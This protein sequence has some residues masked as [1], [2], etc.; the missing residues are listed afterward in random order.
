M[1]PYALTSSLATVATSGLYSDLTG[2]PTI[3]TVG[4]GTI[5][6]NQGGT[7]KGTFTVN[8]SGNTTINLDAGGGGGTV[9][10]TFDGTSQNAQSGVAI[11]GE[12]G[13][14]VKSQVPVVGSAYSN[15]YFRLQ[16]DGHALGMYCNLTAHSSN[17]DAGVDVNRA[18]M[19]KPVTLYY[20]DYNNDI[21]NGIDITHSGINLYFN[22]S[23]SSFNIA[24]DNG[25]V[26]LTTSNNNLAVN[27]SEVAL[28]SD[29]PDISTKQDTLVSGTNIKTINNT[30]LL[31]SGNISVL[32]NTATGTNA[33]TILGTAS[34]YPYSTN[35]GVNSSV[36]QYATAIGYNARSGHYSTAIGYNAQVTS[37]NSAIQIGYGTNNT[38][39][40]LNIGFYNGTNTHYNWQLLD[41]TTGLIPDARIS[42]N[43]ARTSDVA[44]TNLSNLSTTGQAIIDGKAD[45]DLS[46]LSATGK[47]VIDGGITYG[48][49]VLFNSHTPSASSSVTV[50]SLPNDGN[51]YLALFEGSCDTGSTSGNYMQVVISTDLQTAGVNICHARTRSASTVSAAGA[52]WIPI[53]T[54][55][56]VKLGYS[57]SSAFKGSVDVRI[58]EY[59]RL[60]TNT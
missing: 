10:Q 21:Y 24:D 4:N 25:S 16:N 8:Q 51:S 3:P 45:T 20:D 17:C 48:D 32:Q 34:I 7:Q 44:N 47:K 50:T 30:S 23:G 33:L 49:I 18:N 27:G 40:T 52:A 5:P 28:K 26:D 36:V 15:C 38:A 37:N 43:I 35:I 58:K 59:R 53:G 11:E 2:L 60:G 39:N 46:N 56:T 22:G 31:G 1:T 13:K 19:E 6:I 41:G 57:T 29:I 55:R 54:A 14:Y 12:L 9:D 42:S